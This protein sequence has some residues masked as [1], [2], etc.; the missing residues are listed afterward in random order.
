LCC[1]GIL[2]AEVGARLNRDVSVHWTQKRDRQRRHCCCHP[3]VAY[4]LVVPCC[5]GLRERLPTCVMLWNRSTNGEERAAVE[6]VSCSKSALLSNAFGRNSSSSGLLDVS[7]EPAG[8]CYNCSWHLRL[9]CICKIASSV[10]ARWFAVT[11][12]TST[13]A[14]ASWSAFR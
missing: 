8:R 13:E 12:A 10:V 11:A 9:R 7:G 3:I 6:Y 5:Y 1:T 14:V 4:I 2:A